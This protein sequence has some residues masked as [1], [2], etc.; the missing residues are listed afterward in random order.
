MRSEMNLMAVSILLGVLVSGVVAFMYHLWLGVGLFV[1]IL[2]Y[3]LIL[4]YY[5][6]G[7]PNRNPTNLFIAAG[8]RT[9]LFVAVLVGALILGEWI[10]AG[11]TLVM[12]IVT[13][14]MNSTIEPV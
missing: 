10:V 12:F 9:A 5:E 13:V 11:I 2:L 3:T 4:E 8:I 6:R 14:N 1:A 7:A